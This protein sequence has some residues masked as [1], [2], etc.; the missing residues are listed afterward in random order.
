MA[1]VVSELF[2]LAHFTL[3]MS[4]IG[5]AFCWDGVQASL[6]VAITL[7]VM[8]AFVTRSVHPVLP[9]AKGE[10]EGVLLLKQKN[11]PRPLLGKEG[12]ILFT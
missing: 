10:L 3:G 4:R 11:L 6:I 9:L 1:A 7:R 8:S 12:S 2:Q 5:V